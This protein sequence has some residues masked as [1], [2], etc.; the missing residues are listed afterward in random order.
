MPELIRMVKFG[1]KV[2]FSK[3]LA[4]QQTETFQTIQ[5]G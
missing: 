1:M 3:K 2:L 4:K 5:S